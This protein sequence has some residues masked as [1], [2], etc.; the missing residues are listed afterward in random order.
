MDVFVYLCCCI[1]FEIVCTIIHSEELSL[2]VLQMI[3]REDD[4]DVQR[5]AVKSQAAEADREV[6]VQ[7]TVSYGFYTSYLHSSADMF[8]WIED[9]S[10]PVSVSLCPGKRVCPQDPRTTESLCPGSFHWGTRLEYPS[11]PQSSC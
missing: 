10:K 8:L 11:I 9:Q 1:I 7:G 3:D 6:A 2:C 5:E 4:L